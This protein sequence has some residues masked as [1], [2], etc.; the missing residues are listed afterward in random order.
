MWRRRTIKV[1]SLCRA[2]GHFRADF[3]MPPFCGARLCPRRAAAA[4]GKAVR[5]AAGL[6]QG[7]VIFIRRRFRLPD[8]VK[9]FEAD[10][11]VFIGGVLMIKFV[12]HEAVSCRI[13]E[14]I[15][16]AGSPRASRAEPAPLRRAFEDRQESFADCSSFK[17][18]PVNQ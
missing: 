7:R 1:K 12:L 8:F 16:L 14:C 17:K 5:D 3:G 2:H 15:C 6:E 4:R 10:E 18:S 9:L 13:Q 11:R